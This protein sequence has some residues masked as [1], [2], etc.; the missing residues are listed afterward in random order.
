MPLEWETLRDSDVPT[1]GYLQRQN[2]G[3]VWAVC[4]WCCHRR[5]LAL[6]PYVILWG[7]E[8]SSNRLRRALHCRCGRKGCSIQAPAWVNLEIGVQP[9]PEG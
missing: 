1:L 3:W 6:A 5:P 2:G 8:A 9:W 7:P 4:D